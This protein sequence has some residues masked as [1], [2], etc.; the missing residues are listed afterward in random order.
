MPDDSPPTIREN[1]AECW[2]SVGDGDVIGG[3]LVCH[4]C[5]PFAKEKASHGLPLGKGPWS[6]KG[7][8][9][10]DLQSPFPK[11]C[12][13]CARLTSKTLKLSR[14]WTPLRSRLQSVV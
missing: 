13:G 6:H 14:E 1:C 8:F 3:V 2:Q 4:A 7:R 12:W 11:R 10:F 5:A 9:I